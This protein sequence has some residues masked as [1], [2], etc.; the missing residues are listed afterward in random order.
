MQESTCDVACEILTKTRDGNDLD[1]RDL[2]LIQCAVNN[3]EDQD[4]RK[5]LN[6]LRDV[7]REG[8]KKPW[9]QGVEHLTRD[10]EGFIYWK[11]QHVEHY[12]FNDP[13]EE[14]KAAEELAGRCKILEKQGKPI[15]TFTAI[16]L[17][18]D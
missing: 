18:K 2:Y 5:T 1:P 3:S 16:W 6:A 7:V 15:N 17:W 12:S 13:V 8:Y 10:H 11:G 9:V 4:L 14:K